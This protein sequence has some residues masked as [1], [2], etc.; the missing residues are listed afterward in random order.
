MPR[1]D[2]E[3][4]EMPSGKIKMDAD[5]FKNMRN[6]IE[7]IR[8]EAGDYISI[9]KESGYGLKIAGILPTAGNNIEIE[10][11]GTT[12]YKISGLPP[13][14]GDYIQI[15][16]TT[17]GYMISGKFTL[18]QISVCSGGSPAIISVLTPVT[19]STT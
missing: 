10:A 1:N 2:K 16:N 15:D 9:K 19:N 7:T 3:L 17:T 8:P 5:F 13:T 12:G 18:V 14:A 6:R 4:K 11:N